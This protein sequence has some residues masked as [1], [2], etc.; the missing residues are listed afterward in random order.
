MKAILAAATSGASVHR[1]HRLKGVQCDS[2]AETCTSAPEAEAEEK[3]QQDGQQVVAV[4]GSNER[5]TASTIVALDQTFR[6]TNRLTTID[7]LAKQEEQTQP[8]VASDSENDSS[9]PF[10]TGAQ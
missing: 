2:E 4:A 10:H 3:E 1:L 6:H 7:P 5:Y 9:A 8:P